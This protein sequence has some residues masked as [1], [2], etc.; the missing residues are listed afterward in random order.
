MPNLH[1][2]QQWKMRGHGN[3]EAWLPIHKI[4]HSKRNVELDHWDG[5]ITLNQVSGFR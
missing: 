3:Q 5:A 2:G 4:H 1:D